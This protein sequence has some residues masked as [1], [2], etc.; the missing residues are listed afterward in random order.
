MNSVMAFRV[1]VRAD[2]SLKFRARLCPNGSNQKK[3]ADYDE[4]YSPTV[5]R[6]TVF[7]LLHVAAHKDWDIWHVDSGCVQAHAHE[8]DEGR[9]SLRVL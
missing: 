4:T 8:D 3:S 2:G 5:R 7:F 9:Q 6:E 1:S